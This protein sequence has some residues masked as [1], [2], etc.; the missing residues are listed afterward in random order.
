MSRKK[1]ELRGI[2]RICGRNT[3]LTEEHVPPQKAFNKFPT[4]LARFE[5]L[6]NMDPREPPKGKRKQ[7]GTSMYTLCAKCNNDTGA[8][9]G[10]AY[11]DWAHQG[12]R[13]LAA[14]GGQP[15]LAHTY[16]V[17]PLR[18][19]K[20]V[21]TM[22]FSVNT[23][24]F[25]SRNEDLVRF[26]LNRKDVGL[27]PKYRLFAYYHI[28]PAIRHVGLG[29]IYRIDV[30]RSILLSEIASIP[31]GFVLTIDSPPPDRKLCE[32][33]HFTRYGYGHLADVGLQLP[34]L[35]VHLAFP[36]DYRTIPEIV[37]ETEHNRQ[38]TPRPAEDF[39]EEEVQDFKRPVADA[40]T[41]LVAAGADQ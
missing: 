22:F 6:I 37:S 14:S 18:V 35:P 26:V 8:W 34:P 19:I 28:T 41:K 23:E 29:A 3:I 16:Q 13:L 38:V 4:I 20:Q 40:L 33:T 1:T 9:Y 5:D 15:T 39:S 17:Y 31:F 30:G 24:K 2:C 32:I 21:V 10:G 12:M 25:Q 11:V 7:G 27:P 36:G